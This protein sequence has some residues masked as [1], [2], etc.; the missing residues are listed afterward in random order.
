[1]IDLISVVGKMDGSIEI[2]SILYSIKPVRTVD[3][4]P[5][6]KYVGSPQKGIDLLFEDNRVVSLQIYTQA[7]RTFFAYSDDLPFGLKKSMKQNDVHDLL[8]DPAESS[9]ISSKY[10][11]DDWGVKLVATYDGKRNLRLLYV[12]VRDVKAS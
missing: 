9:D 2:E 12:E 11:F 8:G 4:P 7:T 6:R 3:D 5:F 10:V 1:M